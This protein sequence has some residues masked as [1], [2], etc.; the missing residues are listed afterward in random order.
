M[1]L[2]RY[3]PVPVQNFFSCLHKI[4][5]NCLV[6]Y[7]KLVQIQRQQKLKHIVPQNGGLANIDSRISSTATAFFVFSFTHIIIVVL[8]SLLRF[9]K[10]VKL[11]RG[12]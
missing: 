3:E 10:M 9:R 4:G 5:T 2:D 6:D 1:T 7:L 8:I 11:K 12:I